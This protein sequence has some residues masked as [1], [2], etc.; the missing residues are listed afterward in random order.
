M[1]KQQ[2]RIYIDHTVYLQKKKKD[3]IYTLDW[4]L[5]FN[6]GPDLKSWNWKYE[7]TI[8]TPFSYE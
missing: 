2:K 7:L 8:L 4:Y 5:Q 6:Y 3:E 1:Q